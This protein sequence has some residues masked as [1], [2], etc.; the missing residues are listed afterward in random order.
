MSEI[1][2]FHLQIVS[3]YLT[4]INDFISL[5]IVCKKYKGNME[6]FHN[7]PIPVDK[8]T[9]KYF[10]NIETLNL[11]SKT[12]ERFGNDIY[13]NKKDAQNKVDFFQISVWFE[14]E[15]N[16]VRSSKDSN[17]RFH[18][19]TYA[20]KNRKRFGNKIPDCVTKLGEE[21][22]S[23][24]G[25]FK[26]HTVTLP[27]HLK[28]IGGRCFYDQSLE[29]IDLPPSLT[30][31][32]GDYCF[33]QCFNLTSIK[34]PDSLSVLGNYCFIA[35]SNLKSVTMPSHLKR[36]GYYCFEYCYSLQSIEVPDCDELDVY[37]FEKCKSLTSAS[38]GGSFSKIEDNVFAK[39]SS[40]VSI[41]FPTSILAFGAFCFTGCQMESIVLPSNLKEVSCG[42]FYQCSSLKS[43]ILP[44][45][46]SSIG[47]YA[48]SECVNLKTL[49]L[50]SS[51]KELKEQ[52][53]DGC[54]QLDIIVP[55][56]VTFIEEKCFQNCK[57]VVYQHVE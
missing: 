18:N 38:L 56:T 52:C 42:C 4:T 26:I 7:N 19:V 55:S 14:V 25:N 50:P 3:K 44:T 47:E 12:D 32:D 22:F 6:K 29:S 33:Y 40:L 43:V 1:D 20:Q 27:P 30:K 24:D 13:N 34:L 48:F 8:K 49:L 35:C 36:I 57:S 54:T 23:K 37:A 16:T 45:T 28:E 17:I 2:P 31:I 51:V 5:E 10:P 15:Y 11:W 39:C 53:F 46:V 41:N 9:I 21:C